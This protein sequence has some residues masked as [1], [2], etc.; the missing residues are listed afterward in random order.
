MRTLK[1]TE[2]QILYLFCPWKNKKNTTFRSRI[3]QQNWRNFPVLPWLPKR[4]KYLNLS[5]TLSILWGLWPV[6]ILSGGP[7]V[8]SSIAQGHG[9]NY[10]MKGWKAIVWRKMGVLIFSVPDPTSHIRLRFLSSRRHPQLCSQALQCKF[11]VLIYK[12]RDVSMGTFLMQPMWWW[13]ETDGVQ[14]RTINGYE[15]WG[16]EKKK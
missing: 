3:L 6:P 16:P 13:A 14:I 1:C 15:T 12:F 8:Y 9:L 5:L 11:K 4:S 7:C 2:T 10:I